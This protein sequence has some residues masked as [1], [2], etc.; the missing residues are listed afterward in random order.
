M[1]WD[2]Y[3]GD[4]PRILCY[5]VIEVIRVPDG[6]MKEWYWSDKVVPIMSKKCIVMMSNNMDGVS[7]TIYE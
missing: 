7:K 1:G 6:M 4:H 2:K 3:G 5:K